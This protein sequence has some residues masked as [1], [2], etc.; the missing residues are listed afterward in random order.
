MDDLYRLNSTKARLPEDVGWSK[1]MTRYVDFL[2][3]Q[4]VLVP[5]TIDPEDVIEDWLIDHGVDKENAYNI[6][7]HLTHSVLYSVA[8]AVKCAVLD[9]ELGGQDG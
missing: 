5:V 4:E 7:H 1:A 3:D 8:R 2:L 9:A 6:G